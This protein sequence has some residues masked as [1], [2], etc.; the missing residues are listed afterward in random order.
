MPQG[1]FL[2]AYHDGGLLELIHVENRN[3]P[4][5]EAMLWRAKPIWDA[6]TEIVMVRDMDSL[7]VMKDR[8]MMEDFIASEAVMHV[9]NDNP[10]HTVPI[11][12]GLFA[13]NAPKFRELFPELKSWEDMIR[14]SRDLTYHGSDQE[15]LSRHIWPRIERNAST[16]LC[17]HRFRGYATDANAK[18]SYISVGSTNIFGIPEILQRE[19]DRLINHLGTA[20]YDFDRAIQFFDQHGFPDVNARILACESQ[21][22]R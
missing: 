13:V 11:M 3:T 8:R 18:A 2:Q 4:L 9:A 21:V 16:A 15:L 22:A 19:S 7:V 1:K 5:C 20:G 17:E 10:A 6:D 12:G 14:L